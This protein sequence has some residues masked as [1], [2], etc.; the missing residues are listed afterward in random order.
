MSTLKDTY[1]PDMSTSEAA[2]LGVER[3]SK[4]AYAVAGITGV[5]ALLAW[6]D[7]FNL[8]SPWSL[9]D[10]L[11]FALLG[12]FIARRS[13]IAAVLGLALYLLEAIDRLLSGGGGS[14]GGFSILA[15]IFT[16]FFINGIR[17]SFSLARIE[18]ATSQME[19]DQ[20]PSSN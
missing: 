17:G 14:A 6:L 18:K 19:H 20:S 16:F 15:V 9:V 13:R 8:V 11:L 12:F 10:A 4:T 2:A 5:L 7:V 3:A 1:W